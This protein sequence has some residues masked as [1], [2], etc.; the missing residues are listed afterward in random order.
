M[1][2]EQIITMTI[3]TIRAITITERKITITVTIDVKSTVRTEV[4]L[5]S[6]QQSPMITT[7]INNHQQ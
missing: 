6:H 5:K 1:L 3:V 2:T 4:S 7:I